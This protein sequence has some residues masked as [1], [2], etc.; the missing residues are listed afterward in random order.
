V[1]AYQ[2]ELS[3]D[4][5]Q[6][7]EG[8]AE[9][10]TLD[11]TYSEG[12]HR[13][14]LRAEQAPAGNRMLLTNFTSG[15]SKLLTAGGNFI[16]SASGRLMRC[17]AVSG[18]FDGIDG[19]SLEHISEMIAFDA[20]DVTR[21]TTKG[22]IIPFDATV[23]E[24]LGLTA[25]QANLTTP[26]ALERFPDFAGGLQKASTQDVKALKES[27]FTR[28]SRR[29]LSSATTEAIDAAKAYMDR[30]ELISIMTNPKS[31]K[32]MT[33]EE[34]MHP[35]R[36]R[37]LATARAK[38]HANRELTAL[39]TFD[40][41]VAT[42][43]ANPEAQTAGYAFDSDSA[44]VDSYFD[45]ATSGDLGADLS[46]DLSGFWGVS[47]SFVAWSG[48]EY[49]AEVTNRRKLK[50][51][52]KEEPTRKLMLLGGDDVKMVAAPVKVKAFDA[53]IKKDALTT[54]AVYSIAYPG[55]C[56]GGMNT[57]SKPLPPAIYET[58]CTAYDVEK[59]EV[60]D[61][62]KVAVE[63]PP[64]EVSKFSLEKDMLE[65]K[66]F[67]E[68]PDCKP[69]YDAYF[70]E[71]DSKELEK[72]KEEFVD[73]EKPKEPL[74]GEI[75]KEEFPPVPE[76]PM[77]PGMHFEEK[78]HYLMDFGMPPHCGKAI[79]HMEDMKK[80]MEIEYIPI[81]A[82]AQFV[83]EKKCKVVE[84]Q[85]ACI[86]KEEVRVGRK[87]SGGAGLLAP[88]AYASILYKSFTT[89]YVVA[90]QGTK[91][92]EPAML[93]YTLMKDPVVVEFKGT[94]T[95]TTVGFAKYIAQ[96]FPCM[97]PHA[98]SIKDDI[99]YITGHSLG[100]AAATLFSVLGPATSGALV[101]FGAPPTGPH[102]DF[103]VKGEYDL[104]SD[105]LGPFSGTIPSV[106]TIAGTR[107]F[108]K[109]DPV[110]GFY[111]NYGMWA[112]KLQ[113]ALMVYDTDDDCSA[114]SFSYT[115][116]PLPGLDQLKSFLCTSYGV[117]PM[118]WSA[119][120]AYF[121]YT[122]AL[123]PAP[124]AESSFS[125]VYDYLDSL[126]EM[127]MGGS[128]PIWT[129]LETFDS[130]ASSYI[131]TIDAYAMTYFTSALME[132]NPA[133]DLSAGNDP[134]FFLWFY[135]VW[136][137]WWIHSSYPN[138]PDAETSGASSDYG[139]VNPGA[140]PVVALAEQVYENLKEAQQYDTGF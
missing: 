20:V 118:T 23:T 135:G 101:T 22:S 77:K 37:V 72:A 109:F 95:V 112:H 136:G 86:A 78:M 93:E 30:A 19:L 69:W 29:K 46:M 103:G 82:R 68:Y 139:P 58:V 32:H 66:V 13:F 121:S 124:C 106:P 27:L 24:C 36:K 54:A 126:P 74:F 116:A 140:D 88:A 28:G 48:F 134:T 73:E 63:I 70:V 34:L 45:W 113:T 85:G 79:W 42:R 75:P 18:G 91:F 98:E 111:F 26:E 52:S 132:I 59:T 125:F 57:L 35:D 128:K 25:K 55:T 33:R 5:M 84:E 8:A 4:L 62:E 92:D 1:A 16:F 50:E 130:C 41:W 17:N 38:A 60:C 83:I 43:M 3:G 89:D 80:H 96:L 97:V 51:Q 104:K 90:F 7:L 10:A 6:Y 15:E 9:V 67:S 81:E 2:V 44:S 102:A 138:Y 137:L 100:G 129:P 114:T 99:A 108:H 64:T 110:P 107:Y 94:K 115:Q 47:T 133:F 49:Y 87:L 131:A 65:M 127:T 39:T 53:E 12:G 105:E 123:N 117:K 11:G 76:I 71:G 31:G 21:G 56:I 14:R 122:N 61:E 120:A 40:L 119:P